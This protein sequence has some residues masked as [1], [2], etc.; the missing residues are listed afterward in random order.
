MSRS[1]R[2]GTESAAINDGVTYLG[3]SQIR[4]TCDGLETITPFAQT[5]V[6]GSDTF[7]FNGNLSEPS[8]IWFVSEDRA[9]ECDQ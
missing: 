4:W 7:T 1:I 3:K 9:D 2:R 6:G 8:D 5:T